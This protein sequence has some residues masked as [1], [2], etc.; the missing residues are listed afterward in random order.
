VDADTR[1]GSLHSLLGSHRKPGLTD[2]LAGAAEGRAILQSTSHPR[3][4]LIASGGRVP[5]SPELIGSRH[6]ARVVTALRQRYEVV[7]IDSPPMGAGSDATI[8][9]TMTGHMLFVVRSGTTHKVL[10]QVKLAPLR[11]LPVR[12]L[13]VVLNDY[14]PDRL[15]A[16]RYY[17]SYLPGYAAV[18]EPDAAA[19]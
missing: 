11:H 10:T 1:R 2:Y 13:G 9:A 16:Y 5:N 6:M 12:L 7:L 14:V 8:L 19:D 4:D 3:L 18:S 15:T 17:G